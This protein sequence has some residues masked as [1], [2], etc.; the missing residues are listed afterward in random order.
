MKSPDLG[1]ELRIR[2]TSLKPKRACIVI[3]FKSTNASDRL[4]FS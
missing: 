1:V 4:S 2:H 3:Q